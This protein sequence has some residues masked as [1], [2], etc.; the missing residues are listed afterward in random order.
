MAGDSITKIIDIKDESTSLHTAM[1]GG[2]T[3]HITTGEWDNNNKKRTHTKEVETI[4]W[5]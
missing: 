3:T 2:N 5:G 1:W 4:H